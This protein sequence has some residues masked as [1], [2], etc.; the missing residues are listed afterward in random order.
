MKTTQRLFT[1]LA[2]LAAGIHAADVYWTGAAE[3]DDS[4][5]TPGNWNGGNV[6]GESDRA[7]FDNDYTVQ[8][9]DDVRVGSVFV[10]DGK[11][12]VFQGGGSITAV[13]GSVTG[14][15]GAQFNVPVIFPE[16]VNAT[17]SSQNAYGSTIVFNRGLSG[18][19]S[20][21]TGG[22]QNYG[23]R[24]TNGVVSVPLLTVNCGAHLKAAFT[25]GK[26]TLTLPALQ[27]WTMI[28]IEK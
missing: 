5:N 2:L 11:S 14:G 17:A 8:I 12:P 27:Y 1:A 6:P 21:Y 24:L 10:H 7:R 9:D 19:D 13:N 16:G 18:G 20:V 26:V 3:N 23:F 28:V 15:K 4:W 25:G 22:N